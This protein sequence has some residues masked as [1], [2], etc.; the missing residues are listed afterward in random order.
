MSRRVPVVTYK[1]FKTPAVIEKHMKA[2]YKACSKHSTVQRPRSR[3]RSRS[4]SG[5]FEDV[6]VLVIDEDADVVQRKR[7]PV[8]PKRP[9]H[10]MMAALGNIR[11]KARGASPPRRSKSR[12]RSRS[13]SPKIVSG[14]GLFV[15]DL[16][17]DALAKGLRSAKTRVLNPKRLTYAEQRALQTQAEIQARILARNQARRSRSRSPKRKRSNSP[18]R[19]R[20]RSRSRD[21]M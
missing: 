1:T 9:I 16:D 12:S 2:F 7:S 13:R 15:G 10:P 5:D 19:K 6:H 4:R 20:S 8:R 18:K 14:K 17:M 11:L 3:S 21:K